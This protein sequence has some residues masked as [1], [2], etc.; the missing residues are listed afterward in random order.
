IMFLVPLLPFVAMSAGFHWPIQ[1][2]MN[3]TGDILIG[4]MFPIHERHPLWE[5][6]HIQD[7]GLQQLE[8]LLFTIKKINAEKKLLPG[9][10]LGVLAVDSCDSPAYALEQTMDFIK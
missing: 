4:A 8:A 7:E 5:C 2:F 9:I 3:Y 6:G 1:R 10:K